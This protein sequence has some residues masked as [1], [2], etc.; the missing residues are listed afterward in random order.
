MQKGQRKAENESRWGGA[1]G[2][3]STVFQQAPARCHAT[4][5]LNEGSSPRTLL[6]DFPGN[7]GTQLMY[8]LVL[9]T[10]MFSNGKQLSLKFR[11]KPNTI[12]SFQVAFLKKTFSIY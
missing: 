2:E 11:I 1:N 3:I 7:T 8:C 4:G 5:G 9:A 12:F 10:L 6:Q